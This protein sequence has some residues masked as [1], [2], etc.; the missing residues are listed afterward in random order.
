MLQT[1]RQFH[2]QFP[3]SWDIVQSLEMPQLMGATFEKFYIAGMGGS[4]LPGDLIN[5]YLSGT[6]RF[7]LLRDYYLPE[8]VSQNDLLFCSSFSGNTEETLSIYRE[9]KERKIPVVV[10]SHGGELKKR[11]IKNEDVFVPIPDCIQPRCASGHFFASFIGILDR[12]KVIH[13]HEAI[14]SDL[15]AFLQ[16]YR[17]DME[18]KGRALAKKMQ[19]R[20]P[21]IYGPSTLESACRIWKIKLN[22]NAK[23]QAFYNV[24]PELNHNE[25]VG[26]TKIFMKATILYLKSQHMHPRVSKR[27]D[28]LE[29]ILKRKVKFV[30][31]DLIGKSILHELF[32]AIVVADYASFYLAESYGVDPAPVEMVEDFKKKLGP[33]K[34]A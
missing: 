30:E 4:S 19:E 10:F 20:V 24:F 17:E 16:A 1:I 7:E 34:S 31:L 33:F 23:T 28:V 27:M 6:L 18:E 13:S 15:S 11:A 3:K 29:E 9:A 25:M 14:I 5:D 21:I 12:L 8:N 22:E 26:F 32:E 2:E